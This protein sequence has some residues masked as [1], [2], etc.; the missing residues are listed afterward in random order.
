MV[1]HCIPVT[2]LRCDVFDSGFGHMEKAIHCIAGNANVHQ[3]VEAVEFAPHQL[4]ILCHDFGQAKHIHLD[5]IM[6]SVH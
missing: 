5:Q 2:S 3:G 4:G 6:T 1:L